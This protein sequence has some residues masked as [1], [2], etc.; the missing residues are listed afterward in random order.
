MSDAVLE[1]VEFKASGETGAL[2]EAAMAMETWLKAQSG[3]R[4]RRLS[5]LE[6][7][8]FLDTI[9]W[10]DMQSAAAAAAQIMS[11]EPAAGFM[12][13]IEPASVVMRHATIALAQ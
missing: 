2:I 5:Q 11:A 12:A 1:I 10:A 6:C 13:Q 9:E 8:A 4:W 3:F 7:G